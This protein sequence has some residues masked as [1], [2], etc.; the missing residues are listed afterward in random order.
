MAVFYFILVISLFFI[1]HLY[2]Y[3]PRR[4]FVP[5]VAEA[6]ARAAV[7]GED[8][9]DVPPPDTLVTATLKRKVNLFCVYLACVF[10]FVR[11]GGFG[12]GF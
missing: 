10:C 1:P 4:C 8:V 11:V 3:T 12:G 7:G 9:E 6:L 2:V 5:D